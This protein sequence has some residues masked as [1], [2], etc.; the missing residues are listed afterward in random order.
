[1]KSE[2]SF[3]DALD[4]AGMCVIFLYIIL[5]AAVLL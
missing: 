5:A 4:F 3:G 2:S 1:M